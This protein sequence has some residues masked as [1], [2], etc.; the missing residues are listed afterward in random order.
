MPP[1]CRIEHEI[2]ADAAEV[3]LSLRRR[4]KAWELEG[5]CGVRSEESQGRADHRIIVHIGER[6]VGDF[7]PRNGQRG[8]CKPLT[9][10]SSAS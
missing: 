3:L 8:R 4:R 1:T 2:K 7:V 10:T 9:L 5:H 6:L